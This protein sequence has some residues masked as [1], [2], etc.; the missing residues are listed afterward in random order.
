[1]RRNFLSVS[2]RLLPTR[3]FWR[4]SCSLHQHFTITDH[5]LLADIRNHT[6]DFSRF[7]IAGQIFALHHDTGGAECRRHHWHI[8]H[9][10]SEAVDTQNGT[11]GAELLHQN[12]ATIAADASAK[13]FAQGIGCQ[14]N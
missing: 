5:V 14:Q 8:E 10:L 12:T 4:K 11:V 3:R 7:A 1:M 13:R 9:T 2:S 6:V